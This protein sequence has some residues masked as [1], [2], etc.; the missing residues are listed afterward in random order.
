MHVLPARTE[1]L[2]FYLRRGYR[3]SG[4]VFDYPLTADAG[5]PFDP[6]LKLE[7]LEKDALAKSG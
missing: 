5:I 2:A 6:E 1:L 3:R 7:T 4:V